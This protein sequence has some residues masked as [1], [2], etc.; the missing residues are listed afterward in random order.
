MSQNDP[1]RAHAFA[2]GI[3]DHLPDARRRQDFLGY[4]APAS[5]PV[6]IRRNE[7]DG[8]RTMDLRPEDEKNAL[9]PRAEPYYPDK[10]DGKNILKVEDGEE[11]RKRG[12]GT[13][14]ADAPLDLRDDQADPKGDGGWSE[15]KGDIHAEP[16][17]PSEE[18]QTADELEAQDKERQDDHE[19]YEKT[20]DDDED[21]F[22][23]QGNLLPHQ[24]Q[25]PQQAEKP[26]E[27]EQK[28]PQS[29]DKD[30][31]VDELSKNAG[32]ESK[33]LCATYLRKALEKGGLDSNGRPA[34]AKDWGP[35][36]EKNGFNKIA[37]EGYTPKKGDVAIFQP[38]PGGSRDGHITG[39]NGEQW[40]SDFKQ[41]DMWSGPGYR[42]NQ[43]DYTIYRR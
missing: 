37:K 42:R 6:G 29:F 12:S 16:P 25:E 13:D 36:L 41:R 31:F 34:S 28:V 1:R 24:T 9:P 39:Y 43:P 8:R 7:W 33:G 38:Y 4:E 27:G 17:P 11:G 23:E 35:T 18:P 5:R 3:L 19:K 21:D 20:Q 40:I 30:K 2:W 32:D 10:D 22:D 14:G 15:D 26:K